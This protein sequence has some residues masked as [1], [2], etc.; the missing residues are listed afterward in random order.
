MDCF[1]N[2]HIIIT[3][4][5]QF[6]RSGRLTLWDPMDWS[7]PGFPSP[8]PGAYSN[9]C[10]SSHWCHLILFH[11]LLP[12]PFNLSQHQGLFQWVS[13]KHQVAKVLDQGKIVQDS[14]KDLAMYNKTTYILSLKSIFC[15]NHKFISVQSL[16]QVQLFAIP[17]TAAVQASPSFTI[18][19][20]LLKLMPM[21]WCCYPTTSSSV[22]PFSPCP[23]SFPAP[24]SFLI[25]QLFKSGGQSIGAS[26][27]VLPINIQGCFPLRLTGLIFLLSKDSREPS[28][29]PQ[30]ENINNLL[31][32]LKK[33]NVQ[34]IFPGTHHLNSLSVKILH[35]Q[36]QDIDI[37][38]VSIHT[39]CSD[40]IG[41]SGTH[42]C[43][44][45]Y[46]YLCEFITCVALCN[47]YHN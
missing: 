2:L 32:N 23:Q 40:F 4:S 22:A 39:I 20:R 37:D 1:M 5:V 3:S 18:S 27:S 12:P 44:C 26:I 45:M 17:W 47:Y 19:P 29:T 31:Q 21:S 14:Q 38:I 34:G 43:T 35:D 6:S 11:P 10:P 15:Y 46:V 30:F 7:T 41:Y 9:T 8:S 24:G 13:S 36:Y 28:S 25:S 33:K 16:T 42:L